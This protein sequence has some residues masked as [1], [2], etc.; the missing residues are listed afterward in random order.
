M[1]PTTLA[2]QMWCQGFEVPQIPWKMGHQLES[3][4]RGNLRIYL[5][6]AVS[7]PLTLLPF[8]IFNI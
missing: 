7:P 2:Y 4:V 6:F 1:L 5:L 8:P 3:L